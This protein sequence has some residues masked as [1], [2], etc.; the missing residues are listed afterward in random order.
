MRLA[1]YLF[2][3]AL[4][5][6]RF[7]S[8]G[9]GRLSLARRRRRSPSSWSGPARTTVSIWLYDRAYDRELAALDHVPRGARLCQ[10]R[11]PHL[12]RALGDVPAAASA[13][14]GDRPPPRLFQ[15]PMDD[16]RRA[17]AQ[18]PLSATAGR[19]IRDPSQIVTARP[20]PRR[21]A[22]GRSTSALASF[23]RDAFDYVWLIQPPRLRPGA[24][25][26]LQP[27]WRNGAS[28]LYRVADRSAD[29]PSHRRHSNDRAR[30]SRS[31]SPATMRRRA[32]PSCTRRLSR[33][34][35]RGGRRA[36]TRSCWSTTARATAAGR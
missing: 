14:A 24:D 22:G 9:R 21:S 17:I 8:A 34:G 4:I 13:R 36:I 31:S 1:P 26:G 29:R 12:R 7:P 19:F 20:L 30:R 28:V 3:I 18:R 23:P 32:S 25:A 27:V 10:L 6:I 5:A 2:A 15:R 33:G 16:G 11:R 35:A